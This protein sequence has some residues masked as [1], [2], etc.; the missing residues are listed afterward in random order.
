ME[1]RSD[2]NAVRRRWLTL[3]LSVV[4]FV[5]VLLGA[6]QLG[7]ITEM[8]TWNHWTPNYAK[9]DL[10]PILQKETLT[11]EDYELLRRQTGLTKIGIDGFREKGNT[12]LIYKIQNTFFTAPVLR[13]ERYTAFTYVE[14]MNEYI[15]FANLEDGDIV[16]SATTYVSGF[17][18]GHAALVVDGEAER[19]LESYAFGTLSTVT[20]LQASMGN[21]ANIIVVRPKCSKEVRAEVAQRAA[22]EL[23]GVPYSILPGIWTPKYP[24]QLTSTQCSHIVWY[25]YKKYA[26]LDLD[27]DGGGLV[28]P[29]DI[30]LSD[31]VE[32]VQF[33]GFDPDTLWS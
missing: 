28:K 27:S 13:I 23:K 20:S 25:A 2:K 3:V 24:E 11:E 15:T 1:R 31:E 6:L 32:V 8:K 26:G 4:L 16:L 29:Q 7:A 30:F 33:Y 9:E 10:Q 5:S 17:R 22:T 14:Y 19:I 18:H 21:M 12:G